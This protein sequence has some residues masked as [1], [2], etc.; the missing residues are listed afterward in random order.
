MLDFQP[1]EG[2]GHCTAGQRGFL[3]L[4]RTDRFGNSLSSS[5]GEEGFLV[6]AKGPDEMETQVIDCGDGTVDI[7][8]PLVPPLGDS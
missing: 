8:C 3:K 4:R 2:W 6:A 7:R 5:T 1:N